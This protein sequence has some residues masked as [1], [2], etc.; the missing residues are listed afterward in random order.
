MTE[1]VTSGSEA[2]LGAL[3]A[4]DEIFDLLTHSELD[5][6][7]LLNETV[8]TTAERMNLRASAIRLLDEG[9]RELVLRAVY[10][11]SSEFLSA[12]PA[13]DTESRFARLIENDGVLNIQDIL[14]EPDLKFAE[15]AQVE[16]IRSLL[17][18][19]LYAQDELLGALS[20]YRTTPQAFTAAE[21]QSLT[22]IAKQVSLAL[23]IARLHEV[24]AEKDRLER[25][26]TLAGE[27]QQR[28]LPT[29]NPDFPGF[30]IAASYEPWDWIGGD[31]YDFIELPEGNLGIVVADVSGKGI[32][33]ALLMFEIRTAL[34]AHAGYQYSVEE[35]VGRV[36]EQ[37]FRDTEA[38]QFGTLVYGVLNAGG[39][40]FT[41]VNAS[42]PA[43]LLVRDGEV[44]VLDSDDLPVGIL[45][46][47]KFEREIV[48]LEPNDRLILYSDGYFE[49]FNEEGEMFGEARFRESVKAASSLE[50]QAFIEAL[51]EKITH[52]LGSSPDGDDRTL[53]VIKTL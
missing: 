14:E 52:F 44:L 33:A 34:R 50:P 49:I 12:A 8:R 5:L 24:Q 43:P 36:N 1:P 39:R 21:V 31:F 6:E 16:G 4:L 19:G 48:Q 22:T 45:A 38:E 23:K 47:T 30:E 42:N 46:E 40:F 9:S 11:L 10:G 41:Y 28:V 53:V 15:A 29:A 37:L 20:V 25:E 26:L 2:P 35:I 13:F 3:G 51:D 27:I 32:W 17:A 7:R 18:I